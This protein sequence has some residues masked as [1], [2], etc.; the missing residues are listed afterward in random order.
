MCMGSWPCSLSSCP[1]SV[2][3][4]NKL[5]LETCSFG[6]VLYRVKAAT[7]FEKMSQLSHDVQGLDLQ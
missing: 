3:S 7:F 5:S 1:A 6:R 2:S 4:P